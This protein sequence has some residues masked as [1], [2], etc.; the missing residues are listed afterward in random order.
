MTLTLFCPQR[1]GRVQ[2]CNLGYKQVKVPERTKERIKRRNKKS[3]K[4]NKHLCKTEGWH[5]AVKK[6]DSRDASTAR[7]EQREDTRQG[8][9]I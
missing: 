4:K 2:C 8:E 9:S 6:K 7:A 3:C 1:V 5:T